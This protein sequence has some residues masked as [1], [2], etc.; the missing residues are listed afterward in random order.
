MTTSAEHAEGIVRRLNEGPTAGYA[1]A[2]TEIREAQRDNP[3][4]WRQY[5]QQIN[6]Q[7]NFRDLGFNQDFQIVGLNNRGQLVTTDENNPA[8]Q[9]LRG[10]NRLEVVG[11]S[12]TPAEGELWGNNGRRFQTDAEG[13]S[14]F[15]IRQGDYLDRVAA[16]VVAH[17]QGHTPSQQEILRA[18]QEIARENNIRDVNNIPVG[19]TLRI[20]ESLRNPNAGGQD[21]PPP[22][23]RDGQ[24]G[25]Q[26]P[27]GQRGLRPENSRPAAEGGVYNPIAPPGVSADAGFF[28][29]PSTYA[30]REHLNEQTR[31]G[32]NNR[33]IRTYDT[34]VGVPPVGR[35][36]SVS[37]ETNRATGV[38][39][40]RSVNYPQGDVSFSIRNE[41]GSYVQLDN[42]RSVVTTRDQATGQYTSVYTLANGQRWNAVTFPDGRPRYVYEGNNRPR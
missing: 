32:P 26:L 19:T 23:P 13:R 1:N 9:Q 11:R 14:T 24:P 31:P 28:R 39:E 8:Q 6:D 21:A 36:V 12:T 3:N 42:V 35:N 33:D 16:D 7:V 4:F 37:E 15:T 2:V 30:E 41:A 34:I 18:R 22:M 40:R 5:G 38:M 17:N 20:P 10:A 29:H 25:P 27:A